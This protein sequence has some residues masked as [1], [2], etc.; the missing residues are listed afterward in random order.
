M[1][2][3]MLI[4]V[5]VLLLRFVYFL[6]QEFQVK[7]LIKIYFLGG[8]I[9]PAITLMFFTFGTINLVTTIV[10]FIAQTFGAF[11]GA[12]CVYFFYI[13]ILFNFFEE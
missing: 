1:P 10:Y 4:L 12:L 5:G 8:H 13:G 2:G 9:N 6:L 3:L 7:K 11:L